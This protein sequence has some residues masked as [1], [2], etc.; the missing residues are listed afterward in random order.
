M[1]NFTVSYKDTEI[2]Q[3]FKEYS[4]CCEIEF[5]LSDDQIKQ[6]ASQ[7]PREELIGLLFE[8]DE[9]VHLTESKNVG[10]A[11]QGIK[12]IERLEGY[13]MTSIE[14]RITDKLNEVIDYINGDE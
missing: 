14:R 3:R 8:Y 1:K 2:S 6:M 5:G 12:E 9:N 10:I 11:K 7:L 4:D 13:Y